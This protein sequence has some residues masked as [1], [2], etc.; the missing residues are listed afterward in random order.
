[1]SGGRRCATASRWHAVA[2]PARLRSTTLVAALCSAGLLL[3]ACTQS[4]N[5]DA[6]PSDPQPTQLSRFYEQQLSW[7]PCAEFAMSAT[8]RQTF[9]D[10]KFECARLEVP[11]DYATPDGP[12]AKLAVLRQRASGERDRGIL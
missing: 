1:M 9:A 6:G 2:V 3:A 8:D 10:P 7:G 5:G 11:L 12:T 4:T